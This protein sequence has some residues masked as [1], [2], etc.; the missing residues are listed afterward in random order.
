MLRVGI[1]CAALVLVT[2]AT[3]RGVVSSGF[4]LYDDDAYVTE[5]PHVAR[6]LDASS[7]AWAFTSSSQANW[8][9]LTWLSHMTD[10]SLFGLDAGKHHRTSLLLHAASS[11]LL[12]LVLLKMTGAF[13]RCA[14]VAA[15]FAI[16]PLHV[17]SVAWIAER[18]DV[19]S[20][21]FWLLTLWAWLRYLQSRTPLRY[22][23][24]VVLFALGLMAKPMLV[25]LP[26]TLLLLDVWPLG[27][28][29][30]PSLWKE[31]A[32]LFA[33]S[34]MSCA[35]TFIV[36]NSAGAVQP[37]RKIA[38]AERVA[39]AFLAYATYL[40]QTFWPKA[41]AVFYPYPD[42]LGLLTWPVA[43]SALLLVATTAIV[44]R[45][46]RAAPFL[47]VGW[48]WYLGTL[49][50]VIGL[51]QVGG[52]AMADRYTYVPLIGIFIAVSWGAAELGTARRTARYSIVLCAAAALAALCVLTRLQV[53]HWEGDIPLFRHAL[54]VTSRNWLA[55]NNLG[56]ALF[57][58]GQVD[59]AIAE[60][61]EALSISPGYA[62]AHYNLG[63]ALARKGQDAEAIEQFDQALRLAPTF[64]GAH[65]NLGGVLAGRGQI[66]AAIEHYDLAMRLDPDNAEA[67]YN[68]GNALF[69]RGRIDAAIA[70]YRRA[71]ALRPDRAEVH[72]NLGNALVRAGRAGEAIEQ[73]E[74]ALRIR[75]DFSEARTNLRHV[76]DAMSG[77]PRSRE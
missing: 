53:I 14:F 45:L 51:V 57:A 9:P 23:I 26:F 13:W 22:A 50:P 29:P 5:N 77:P 72:N 11:V 37:L 46:R 41:L 74:Q 66:D 55:H 35:V 68:M 71:L 62:D 33:M 43:G 64:A 16:H 6:G 58:A 70:H 8:H 60:Y 27:R 15:L 52:Q 59:E 47:A 19:L 75:P 25:T 21:L 10:V 24:V 39:N 20:T 40:G 49:V 12:F 69:A 34:A 7:I 18:K 48:L 1:L 65:N 76:N 30:L 3:Y 56:R 4:I 36:Q 54:Q 73:Y 32:P 28:T 38:F 42:R 31:K 17:E 67:P 61:G 63:T 44:I 2:L